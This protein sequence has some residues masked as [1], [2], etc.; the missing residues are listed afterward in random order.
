MKK[1]SFVFLVLMFSCVSEQDK[2]V[3]A[4]Y[5]QVEGNWVIDNFSVPSTVPDTLKNFFTKGE[6]IFNNC[7]YSSKQTTKNGVSCYGSA[8]INGI[9]LDIVNAY[10]YDI[11]VFTWYFVSVKG[12]SSPKV[13]SVIQLFDGNW[14]IVVNGNKMTARRIGGDRPYSGRDLLYKGEVSF[15]ATKK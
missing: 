8:Q 9:V 1:Y 11:K 14:D 10:W 12:Q 4:Q 13:N 2:F 7:K 5:N 3:Q 6:I 15:T